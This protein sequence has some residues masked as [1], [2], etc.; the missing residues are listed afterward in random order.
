MKHLAGDFKSFN[1]RPMIDLDR[2][3]GIEVKAQDVVAPHVIRRFYSIR[4][5]H[6]EIVAN[7]ECGET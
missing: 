2:W 7:A 1:R 6:G 5:V 4:K 3:E